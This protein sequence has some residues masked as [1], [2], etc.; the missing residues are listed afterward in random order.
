M[1]LVKLITA[2]DLEMELSRNMTYKKSTLINKCDQFNGN[3]H[4]RK[5]PHRC[6]VSTEMGEAGHIHKFIMACLI[7][8]TIGI[9]SSISENQQLNLLFKDIYIALS[10]ESCSYAMRL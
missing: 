6:G 4:D 3:L 1:L 2:E 10:D 5:Y 9:F 8:N 7:Q